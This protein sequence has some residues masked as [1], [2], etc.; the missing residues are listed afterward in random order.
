MIVIRS[1]AVAGLL[2]ATACVAQA[3]SIIYQ[4]DF[5][6]SA[7]T[8]LH[9]LSPDV[10]NSG[11]GATWVTRTDT[12]QPDGTGVRWYADGSL[13][14]MLAGN[15]A[16]SLPFTPQAGNVYTLTVGFNAFTGPDT[17][18]TAIG[19]ST[20]LATGTGP[21]A[22]FFGNGFPDQVTG[23][24]WMLYRVA[25][26]VH[27]GQTFI[28]VPGSTD[29]GAAWPTQVVANPG[30][31]VEMR[32]ILDTTAAAWELEWL[33]KRPTDAN[34]TS[35]RTATYPSN[36]TDIGAASIA[37]NEQLD[38]SLDYLS[39]TV[40]GVVPEPASVLLGVMGLAIVSMTQ[41][42]RSTE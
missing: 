11:L 31:P 26:T 24:G 29:G 13:D 38:G 22:D 34:F 42:R 41:R 25:G 23:R 7:S 6:G 2:L 35:L 17:F 39:L 37:A 20:G 3:Q 27:P 9:G 28:G 18:W 33:A 36:P 30:D 10:D 16:A 14:E 40:E 19:Y 32:V 15:G 21:G 5:T 1:L 8:P 4:H 12:G